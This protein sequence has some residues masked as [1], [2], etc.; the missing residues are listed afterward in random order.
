M[1]TYSGG[2]DASVGLGVPDGYEKQKEIATTLASKLDDWFSDLGDIKS[3]PIVAELNQLKSDLEA[4]GADD[5]TIKF[6][7]DAIDD[8]TN[9]SSKELARYPLDQIVSKLLYPPE[10]ETER[11]A[12]KEPEYDD[13]VAKYLPEDVVVVPSIMKLGI[14][15]SYSKVGDDYVYSIQLINADRLPIGNA[16]AEEST[17]QPRSKSAMKHAAMKLITTM[18]QYVSALSELVDAVGTD[19]HVSSEEIDKIISLAEGLLKDKSL[20]KRYFRAMQTSQYA[21]GSAKRILEATGDENAFNDAILKAFSYA[22]KVLEQLPETANKGF[23]EASMSALK[24]LVRMVAEQQ[25][26][27]SK[28]GKIILELNEAAK[29]DQKSVKSLPTVSLAIK[30]LKEAR[31]SSALGNDRKAIAE[32]STAVK[33]IKI[34]TGR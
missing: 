10:L 33:A 18:Q 16:I 32:V 20:E 31:K 1:K 14:I 17:L 6:C 9:S 27:S 4:C 30:T 2:S 34:L 11:A 5:E 23:M 13:S 25:P 21:L 7:E 19:Q 29:L 12:V 3:E 28:I 15:K 24:S 8:M 22:S 26:D